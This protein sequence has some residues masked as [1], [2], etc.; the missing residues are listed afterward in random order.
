MESGLQALGQHIPMGNTSPRM[1]PGFHQSHIPQPGQYAVPPPGAPGAFGDIFSGGRRMQDPG[2]VG[3]QAAQGFQV[4]GNDSIAGLIGNTGLNYGFQ[5]IAKNFP[6]GEALAEGMMPIGGLTTS[7]MDFL[8]MR[9]RHDAMDAVFKNK[10]QEQDPALQYLGTMGL[11][12]TFM[13][14]AGIG[15][16]SG[17]R[18]RME[19]YAANLGRVFGGDITNQLQ[20]STAAGLAIDHS[21]ALEGGGIDFNLTQGMNNREMTDAIGASFRRGAFVTARDFQNLSEAGLSGNKSRARELGR[22]ITGD[23][24]NVYAAGRDVFGQDATDDEIISGIESVFGREGMTDAGQATQRLREIEAA[25]DVLNMDSKV[26]AK[27]MQVMKQMTRNMG[28]IGEAGTDA[29]LG[30]MMRGKEVEQFGSQMGINVDSDEVMGAMSRSMTRNLASQDTNKKESLIATLR[31]AS[32]D[33]LR[34]IDL[35]VIGGKRQSGLDVLNH[36][37]KQLEGG[38]MDLEQFKSFQSYLGTAANRLNSSSDPRGQDLANRMRQMAH[39]PQDELNSMFS[40]LRGQTTLKEFILGQGFNTADI[41]AAES[42]IEATKGVLD[43][44]RGGKLAKKHGG[45][46]SVMKQ[47]AENG[48]LDAL[49]SGDLNSAKELIGET[50]KSPNGEALSGEEADSMIALFQTTAGQV[51]RYPGETL[52]DSLGY[53]AAWGRGK[54]GVGGLN[55]VLLK[56]VRQ[57]QE[58]A[59]TAGGALSGDNIGQ[60]ALQAGLRAIGKG[61]INGKT[62]SKMFSDMGGER[63]GLLSQLFSGEIKGE[64]DGEE[65][66]FEGLGKKI[67]GIRDNGEL[68]KKE[69][70]QQINDL[71]KEFSK[72]VIDQKFGDS[73]RTIGDVLNVGKANGDAGPGS[74]GKD[75]ALGDPAQA[76]IAA[77]AEVAKTKLDSIKEVLDQIKAG[78]EAMKE[79]ET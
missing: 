77:I 30:M 67:Q 36:L 6:S 43:I 24:A 15:A 48:I 8:K 55:S 76:A 47:A 46:D 31:T 26:V 66:D 17:F 70:T 44:T 59:G 75:V 4:M 61:E 25:G 32:K 23:L 64:I 14:Q 56:N 73:D 3:F 34:D 62:L 49:Q 54:R 9:Q 71:Q 65:I 22:K 21:M 10:L 51:K 20:R 39:M 50:F 16:M 18:T 40:G 72:S 68:T 41:D 12:S 45:L 79:P 63:A 69:K 57:L 5:Q 38:P 7:R 1:P 60:R 28:L 33:V 19:S 27:Y 74:E 53:L 35:G 52:S 78:V 37:N 42:A 29:A 2:N 58:L 13:G 11:G